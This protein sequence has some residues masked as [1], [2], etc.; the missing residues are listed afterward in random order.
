MKRIILLTALSLLLTTTAIAE[1]KSKG[2]ALAELSFDAIDGDRKGYLHLGDMEEGRTNI[3]ASMDADDDD[4][5]VLEEFLEWDYGFA[6]IAQDSNKQIA[7]RT[8]LK[9]VFN[10]WDRNADGQITQTEH[11]QAVVR[12]FNRA[13]INHD[14][15]L[16]KGEFVL[17]L[18]VLVA[19]RAALKPE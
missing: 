8:A 13:D 17:G 11:R 5:L 2:R 6:D 4:N 1:Q 7:Y 9:V 14:G 12:D 19:I 18:S 3:F 10:L 16:N 15:L